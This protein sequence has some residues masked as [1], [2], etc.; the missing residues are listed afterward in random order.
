MSNTVLSPDFAES[1]KAE[2]TETTEEAM[3][4]AGVLKESDLSQYIPYGDGSLS[5]ELFIRLQKT[6]QKKLAELIKE[7]VINQN[8]KSYVPR[9]SKSSVMSHDITAELEKVIERAMDKVKAQKESDL[10]PYIPYRNKRLHHFTYGRLKKE[11][12]EDVLNL[13]QE[14]ILDKPPQKLARKY[15]PR[16][17][18]GKISV[19]DKKNV[20]GNL[21]QSLEDIINLAME[22][23][24]LNLQKESDL[25]WF[26]PSENGGY[27]FYSTYRSLK[28]KDPEKLKNLIQTYIVSPTSPKRF[29]PTPRKSSSRK[30]SFINS[31]QP[32]QEESSKVEHLL[33]K[34]SQSIDTMSEMLKS[35]LESEN[36]PERKR[37]TPIQSQENRILQTIQNQLIKQIRRK[38][39]DFELWDT[40]VELIQTNFM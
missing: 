9:R 19:E 18:K 7:N 21:D 27:L 22:R 25:C 2:L 6:D 37:S 10:C 39:V 13:I 29:P 34:T 24:S 12:P 30:P 35:F 28:Q 11:Y 33:E 4:I 16:T 26:I 32:S 31:P 1:F 5:E 23:K 38:E 36:F 8:P 17:S 40:Y 3:K 15:R 14:H 20:S